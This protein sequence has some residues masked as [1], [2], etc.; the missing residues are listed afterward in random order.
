MFK[1]EE[2]Y[3]CPPQRLDPL[4]VHNAGGTH[5]GFEHQTL[6]VYEQMTLSAFHLLA[7]IVSSLLFSYPGGLD[8]LAIADAGTRLRISPHTDPLPLTQSSEQLLPGA[9]DAPGAEV[10]VDGLLGREVVR[11]KPPGTS[12]ADDVEDGV[13][14]LAQGVH[15]GPS[16]GFWS[17]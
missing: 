16:G 3:V 7:S 14:D 8:R 15:P 5:L 2:L 17:R 1:A 11:Q 9:V 4:E 13:K 10:M 12:A 6:R